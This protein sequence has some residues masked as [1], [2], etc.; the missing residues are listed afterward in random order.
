MAITPIKALLFLAGCTAAAG[1]MAYVSGV[2][3][4]YL[5]PAAVASLDP[6]TPQQELTTPTPEVDPKAAR[7]PGGAAAPEAGT[8]AAAVSE[9]D[10]AATT[11]VAESPVPEQ[12]IL[13][14]SFDVVRVESGGSIVI[15]G[16]AAPDATVEIVTGARILGKAVAG[17]DG[18]FAVVIDNPLKPGGYQIVLRS[19]T[20]ENVVATSP[21]TAV[22]SIP[23]TEN[24]QVL[25]LVEKP[26]EPSKLITVPEP[27]PAAPK[28]DDGEMATSEKPAATVTTPPAAPSAPEATPS[29]PEAVEVAKL[30]EATPAEPTAA[31][32]ETSLAPADAAAND[33]APA[34]AASG[35][36]STAPAE[37]QIEAVAMPDPAPIEIVP[38]EPTETPKVAVEAVEIEGRKIFVAGVADKGRKVRA[39]ANDILLGEAETSAGGRFLIETE[40]DLPVG[41]YIIRVDALEPNGVKVAARAAVPFEREPG[42]AIAAVA[43]T[44]PPETADATAPATNGSA[45][46][47]PS[48]TGTTT[49]DATAAAEAPVTSGPAAAQPE[50]AKTANADASAT[51]DAPVVAETAPPTPAPA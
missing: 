7:L 42:E 39:Y 10:S 31:P 6:Q 47:Q 2:F 3:D 36:A 11:P 24:G 28:P 19:T 41:D 1:A 12:A 4:P 30:P 51:T 15:A 37:Q 46:S 35:E 50:A 5:Q 43:P 23:E 22:V 13:A 48:P 14:P 26:G 21:E 29:A 49:A 9:P 40:R 44:Q 8:D 20:P 16:R 33:P 25:A 45:A 27:E 32:V 38:S 18:D 34:D 17:A